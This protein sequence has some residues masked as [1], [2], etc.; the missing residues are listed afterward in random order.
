MRYA[1]CA[2]RYALCVMQ[3]PDVGVRSGDGVPWL[4]AERPRVRFLPQHQPLL[5]LRPSW[6]PGSG[7]YCGSSSWQLEQGRGT[8]LTTLAFL[9]L[10]GREQP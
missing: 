6:T 7:L 8:D 1:L 10:A 4:S 9:I 2:M 3:A 5:Q